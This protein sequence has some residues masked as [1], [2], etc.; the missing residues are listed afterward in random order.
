MFKSVKSEMPTGQM[1]VI[2]QVAG[3][4]SL[5]FK[6]MSEQGHLGAASAEMVHACPVASVVPNS[7]QHCGLR[8]ARLLN[9][10]NFPDK[11]TG[12]GYHFLLQGIFPTQ[13]SN[14]HLL[15]WQILDH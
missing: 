2:K 5:K 14:L 15:H 12:V 1:Q 13:G 4:T 8:P 9:P 10:W 6:G 3:Y 7:W 11:N